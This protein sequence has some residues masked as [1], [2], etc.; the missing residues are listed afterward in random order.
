MLGAMLRRR[1]VLAGR[2]AWLD[3][4]ILA[5]SAAGR[6]SGYQQQEVAAIAW[7]ISLADAEIERQKQI[8]YERDLALMA[9]DAKG[10]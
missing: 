9:N 7:A 2:K 1:K 3:A 5:A 4:Q 6:T 8:R 10:G